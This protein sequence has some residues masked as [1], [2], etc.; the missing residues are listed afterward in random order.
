MMIFKLISLARGFQ[1]KQGE[2]TRQ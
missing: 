2:F 1:W